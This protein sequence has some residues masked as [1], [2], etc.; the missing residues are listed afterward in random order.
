MQPKFYLNDQI[1]LYWK[2][3][4]LVSFSWSI[5]WDRLIQERR[6]RAGNPSA[7]LATLMVL[8]EMRALSLNK[9][10]V[11]KLADWIQ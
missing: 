2:W 11:A 3:I 10:W 4:A 6:R 8:S 1:G 5:E 9:I 7:D